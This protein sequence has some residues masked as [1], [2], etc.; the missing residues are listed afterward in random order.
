M[1]T[2]LLDEAQT[3]M[4]KISG[5]RAGVKYETGTSW[6]IYGCAMKQITKNK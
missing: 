5:G 4:W 1:Y 2:I 6:Q 3:T